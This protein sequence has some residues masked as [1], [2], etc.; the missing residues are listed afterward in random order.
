MTIQTHLQIVGASLILLGAANVFLPRH[1]NWKRDL[2]AVPL[3]TR[4][5]FWVHLAFLVITLEL[6]GWSTL[7]NAHALLEPGPLSR[8][9]LAGMAIFW[10]IRLF[11]QFFV[12]EPEL[13]RG[14]RFRTRI[15]YG[16]SV[17]WM[18]LAGT[19]T[20]ALWTIRG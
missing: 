5:V 16:I 20:A 11:F 18:Y 3:F 6:F 15:H 17:F 12:Y 10:W 7:L 4:R 1:F 8:T 9:M 2:T 13:W 14:D 19:Y